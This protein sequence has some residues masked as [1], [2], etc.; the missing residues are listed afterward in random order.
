MKKLRRLLENPRPVPPSPQPGQG[1]S[2]PSP[3]SSNGVGEQRKHVLSLPCDI[4]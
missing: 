3:P 4:F 1:P 2:R